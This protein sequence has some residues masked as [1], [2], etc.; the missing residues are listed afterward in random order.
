MKTFFQTGILLASLCAMALSGCAI[1]HR[2]S[3]NA[4]SPLSSTPVAASGTSGSAPS[5]SLPV[6]AKNNCGAPITYTVFISNAYGSDWSKANNLIAFNQQAGDGYYHIYTVRPDGSD[7]QQVGAGSPTFPQ[8][9]TGTPAW[10]PSGQY[11]AFV[12]EKTG[13]LP[14]SLVGDT[15]GA[16]PGWGDYTDLW[17]SNA[18]GSKAWQLTDLPAAPHNQTFI[19]QFSPNGQLLEWTEIDSGIWNLKIGHFN[20]SPSGVPSLS[21][22]QTIQS[23]GK[24]MVESGGFSADSSTVL[25]TSAGQ[26]DSMN[27]S[28]GEITR[29]T[30]WNYYN[31]HPRFTPDGRVIWM[32]NAYQPLSH[33]TGD[34]WWIMSADGSNPQRLSSF[35]NPASSEYFGQTVYATVVNTDSWSADGASFYGDVELSIVTSKSDIVRASLTCH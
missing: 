33:V 27:L 22:I 31:E 29:L 6:S 5:S 11:M 34:D 21:G 9:T 2:S 26:I 4:S 24:S 12:A 23:G 35:N 10:S 7:R 32:S 13:N 15:F 30:H 8:R 3:G 25:F 1:P 28:S 20:V 14:G 19:P 17:V 16:T 18:N